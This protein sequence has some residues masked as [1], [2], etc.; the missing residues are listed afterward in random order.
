[1]KISYKKF[2]VQ[3]SLSLL[4]TTFVLSPHAS[5]Q[6]PTKASPPS[7]K[8]LTQSRHG[9]FTKQG[10]LVG[11]IEAS[12]DPY[13]ISSF[14]LLLVAG[15]NYVGVPLVNGR[16][17][18]D[19]YYNAEPYSANFWV[20]PNVYQSDYFETYD[21]TGTP[22]IDERGDGAIRLGALPGIG[23]IDAIGQTR[24]A[25]STSVITQVFTANSAKNPA[26]GC[27]TQTQQVLG[28]KLSGSI[29]FPSQV[30]AKRIP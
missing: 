18:S 28:Y 14:Y 3:K 2:I 16:D 13:R 5:A 6:T 10:T 1:M 26:Y 19:S 11:L 7:I 4:V 9:A 20:T 12:T 23:Y 27:T 30:V 25:Y 15:A 8:N 22:I 17:N 21:C 24:I 29:A